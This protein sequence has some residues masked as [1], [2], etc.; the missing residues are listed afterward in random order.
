M[1]A[2]GAWLALGLLAGLP[3]GAQSVADCDWRATLLAL[4][5]PWEDV[6]R[7]FAN[8]QVRLAIVDTIEPAAG[9]LHMVVLSP[10]YDEL[11]GRQCKVIGAGPNEGFGGLTLEGLEAA[12]DP[13]RG[14]TFRAK[15]AVFQAESGAFE[16]GTLVFT[17]NQSTGALVAEL[18]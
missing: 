17:L 16:D 18:E 4:P 8:G 1:I 5:E 9:A 12:Y 11:G 3:A 15:A 2:R 7:T 13:A 10:P 6:T 14:L